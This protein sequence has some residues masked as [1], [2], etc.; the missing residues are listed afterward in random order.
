MSDNKINF[1]DLEII[2][3]PPVKVSRQRCVIYP[4]TCNYYKVIDEKGSWLTYAFPLYPDQNIDQKIERVKLEFLKM[5]QLEDPANIRKF[6]KDNSK[7]TAL[8]DS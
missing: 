2:P 7:I 3:L 4:Y 1:E 8:N 6:E 5:L